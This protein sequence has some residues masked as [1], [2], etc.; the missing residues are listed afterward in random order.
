MSLRFLEVIASG[1]IPLGR[2][3]R[4]M[5]DLFGY[6]PVIE[7]DESDPEGQLD[8]LLGGIDELTGL[9]ERNLETLL[10]V[11]PWERRADDIREAIAANDIRGTTYGMAPSAA[12]HGPIEGNPA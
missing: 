2:C 9:R 6:N 1:A 3:P 11:A 7:I 5:R 4:E 10:R 8:R 12:V